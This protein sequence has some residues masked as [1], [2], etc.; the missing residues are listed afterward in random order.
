[1]QQNDQ[2]LSKQRKH[3]SQK[4]ADALT[5]RWQFQIIQHPE[6]VNLFSASRCKAGPV[7]L[8][9]QSIFTFIFVQPWLLGFRFVSATPLLIRYLQKSMTVENIDL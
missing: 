9:I 6:R 5:D 7:D 8:P 1:M 4:Y 2:N 3:L